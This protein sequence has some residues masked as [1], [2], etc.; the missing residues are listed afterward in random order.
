MANT[1]NKNTKSPFKT[2]ALGAADDAG[3]FDMPSISTVARVSRDVLLTAGA[4][5]V[6]YNAI[7]GK[8][9]AE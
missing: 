6:L 7:K 2:V 1:T 3:G 9:K 4:G 5:V 8:G